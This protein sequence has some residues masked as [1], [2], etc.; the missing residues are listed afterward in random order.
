MLKKLLFIY[1]SQ[2]GTTRSVIA[3]AAE[4]VNEAADVELRVLRAQEASSSD[5][6]W[7]D[8]VLLAT[9]E[10]FG[11]MS[12]GLKDFF[13]RSFY[14][15]ESDQINRPYTLLVC[16]GND[17]SQA[18]QEVQRIVK[19]YPLKPVAEPVIIR[20]EAGEDALQRARELALALAAGLA[21]G[22]F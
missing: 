9:P 6:L 21:M 3:A 16:A 1:H 20:G 19:G 22:I 2:S 17:G 10:N 12:G 13:D 15:L 7:C 18:V 4:A 8:G 14:P 11:R 5:L